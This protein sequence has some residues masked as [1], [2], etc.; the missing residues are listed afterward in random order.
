M[1]VRAEKGI[2]LRAF[3]MTAA[4]VALGTGVAILGYFLR[5]TGRVSEGT[6]AG[7]PVAAT[8]APATPV[9]PPELPRKKVTIFYVDALTGALAPESREIYETTGS[10]SQC[11]QAIA[12]LLEG[13][14]GGDLLPP[15][16]QDAKLVGLFLGQDGQVY[17][18]FSSEI[19]RPTGVGDELRGLAALALTLS[20][21]FPEIE[22]MSILIEGHEA[23][24]LRGHISIEY[25]LVTK[26][27]TYDA[28]LASHDEPRPATKAAS[29]PDGEAPRTPAPR[30]DWRLEAKSP[31]KHTERPAKAPGDGDEV[32]DTKAPEEPAPDDRDR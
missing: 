25:P 14:Q 16:P 3:A 15:L 27:A 8:T 17:L 1:R 24:V 9:P 6:V 31:E 12:L 7:P 18:D 30:P 29:A 5:E 20:R 26:D 19:T 32:D 28:L 2:F 22:H 4:I 21:N 10:A 11:K 13:P 23:R